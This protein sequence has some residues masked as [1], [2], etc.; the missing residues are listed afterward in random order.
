MAP[1]RRLRR[2]CAVLVYCTVCQ[3]LPNLRPMNHDSIVRHI[4]T[5]LT[6]YGLKQE[7]GT[8]KGI[9]KELPVI[10]AEISRLEAEAMLLITEFCIS[11]TPYQPLFKLLASMSNHSLA[12]VRVLSRALLRCNEPMYGNNHPMIQRRQQLHQLLRACD[13]STESV[14]SQQSDA[15]VVSAFNEDCDLREIA[16]LNDESS[17]EL[18]SDNLLEDEIQ[19]DDEIQPDDEDV[20]PANLNPN[21]N[22]SFAWPD[23][24]FVRTVQEAS[25]VSS[26][27]QQI[28]VQ[29]CVAYGASRRLTTYLSKSIRALLREHA[30]SLG[31]L[32]V[33][34]F[35]FDGNVGRHLAQ[36]GETLRVQTMRVCSAPNCKT[37]HLEDKNDI[38]CSVCKASLL[39]DSIPSE[40]AVYACIKDCLSLQLLNPIVLHAVKQQR[41]E[42][43]AISRNAV[44]SFS[45]LVLIFTLLFVR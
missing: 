44:C 26:A 33:T 27:V 15:V 28:L 18:V 12:A 35:H 42:S 11:H 20:L 43:S 16:P 3:H 13:V 5:T 22:N 41:H 24:P 6:S 39:H 34:N 17:L 38:H 40:T 19:S 30:E 29:S 32:D 36:L 7:L 14:E 8:K 4:T 2:S 25:G 45:S 10:L 9:V 23:R 1:D 37:L 21:L 31:S